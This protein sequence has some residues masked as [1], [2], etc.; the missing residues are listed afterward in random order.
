MPGIT[1][2]PAALDA[3]ARRAKEA[4][5]SFFAANPLFLKP[6]S[7]GTFL[8]FVRQHFP[9]LEPSYEKRYADDAF[10]S[11]AYQKRVADLVAAVVRKY[12]LGRRRGEIATAREVYSAQDGEA[13]QLLWP[14]MG[15]PPQSAQTG[16]V[17][18]RFSA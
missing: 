10:V 2:T 3:M 13:Q 15:K 9:A 1:D 8:S 5:A 18:R 11:K 7:K 14:E 12:G 17:K 4:N 6:C 16:G